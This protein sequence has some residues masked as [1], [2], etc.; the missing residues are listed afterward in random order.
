M[1]PVRAG[2]RHC[3]VSMSTFPHGGCP[4]THLLILDKI[5]SLMRRLALRSLLSYP[6]QG[7]FGKNYGRGRGFRNS[8]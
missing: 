4:H 3:R 6:D 8:G 2:L 7:C 1:V 5:F